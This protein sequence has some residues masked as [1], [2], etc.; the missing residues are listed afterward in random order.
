MA[1]I[2]SPEKRSQNM[3]AIRSKNTKPEVYLR[4]LLFA[5]GYR[6]RIADKSVP[7]H[8]DIFL[9]KYNTAIFVNGGFWHR[10][11][12]CKYAYTPKSRVEFW[13][14]KFDDNVRRDSAVKAEL[15]EHGIKLLTVWEC[16]IRRMQRDKIEEERALTKI[17]LFIKS[18][19]KNAEIM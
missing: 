9:R 11:P 16:A 1:D 19:E 13:Q 14:K 5:Q 10:H 6:Y 7:G 3:S 4:K 12:G 17:I 15:L 18:N 8:P 2:V